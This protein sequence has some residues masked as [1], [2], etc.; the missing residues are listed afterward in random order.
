MQ[1]NQS[2]RYSE[3]MGV[4]YGHQADSDRCHLSDCYLRVGF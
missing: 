1:S 3:G 4:S 2:A